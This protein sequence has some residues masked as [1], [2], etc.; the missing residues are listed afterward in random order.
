MNKLDRTSLCNGKNYKRTFKTNSL[1]NCCKGTNEQYFN[2]DTHICCGGSL[3][4]RI[5]NGTVQDCCKS[6]IYNSRKTLCCGGIHYPIYS[7][8]S[9]ACC[10]STIYSFKNEMC[11]GYKVHKLNFTRLCCG[12]ETFDAFLQQCYQDTEVMN[13][14]ESKCGDTRYD[15]RKQMC[16]NQVLRTG[17]HRGLRCCGSV[18]FNNSL[19]DCVEKKVVTKGRLLCQNQGE[20][21]PLTHDCCEGEIKRRNGSWWRCCGSIIINYE[22]ENCCAGKGYHKRNEQCCGGSVTKI[23]DTCCDGQI[24]DPQNQVCCGKTLFANEEIIQKNNTEDD[25][26]CVTAHGQISYNSANFVCSWERN[27]VSR[28]N[29]RTLCGRREF[30]PKEDLCCNSRIFKKALQKGMQCCM[31]S[32]SIYNSRTHTCCFGIKKVGKRC[33]KTKIRQIRF[34]RRCPRRCV[35]KK[36][37]LKKY[38]KTSLD[39]YLHRPISRLGSKMKKQLRLIERGGSCK[40]VYKRKIRR[41]SCKLTRDRCFSYRELTGILV[42]KK[43]KFILWYFQRNRKGIDQTRFCPSN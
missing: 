35:R 12:N 16:C 30:N 2:P 27:I 6:T 3:Y 22:V 34:R 10:G 25:K 21:N 8:D 38:C 40:C 41:D 18:T 15:T 7:P 42:S 23:E 39:T 4:P 1:N 26:C 13:V 33:W 32:A 36:M 31:P 28:K 14:F 19:N 29:N 20:Y 24:L 43:R 37:T 5:A 17:N 9:N 11:C